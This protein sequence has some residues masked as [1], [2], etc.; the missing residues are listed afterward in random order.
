[1]DS[2]PEI[3]SFGLQPVLDWILSPRL[4]ALL[5]GDLGSPGGLTSDTAVTT[6]ADLLTVDVPLDAS[7]RSER[8]E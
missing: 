3:L 8:P 6:M 4:K 2:S 5:A 7:C 1:M